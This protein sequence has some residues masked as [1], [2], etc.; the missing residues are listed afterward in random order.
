MVDS[1]TNFRFPDNFLIAVC[2]KMRNPGHADQEIRC[3]SISDSGACRSVIPAM[4]ITDSGEVD[5]ATWR[6]GRKMAG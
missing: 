3:M 4:P 6:T 5:Q 1:A 2:Y